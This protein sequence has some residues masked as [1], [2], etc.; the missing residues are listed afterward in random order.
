MLNELRLRYERLTPTISRLLSWFN[1]DRVALLVAALVLSMGV[2]LPWYKI[3]PENLK[4]FNIGLSVTNIGRVVAALFACLCFA[5][6]IWHQPSRLPRLPIWSGLIGTLLFPYMLTTWSPAVDFIATSLYFQGQSVTMHVKMNSNKVQSQWKKNVQLTQSSP[7]SSIFDLSIRTSRFF[8]FSLWDRILLAGLGYSRPF[9]A[10]VGRG[11]VMTSA[12]LAIAV[13]AIYLGLQSE[14]YR[15]FLHDMGRILPWSVLLLGVLTF[16]MILPSMINYQLDAMFARG[17]YHQVIST[18][19]A[20]ISF[21]PPVKGDEPFLKRMA[22]AGYYGKEPDPSLINFAQGLE[23]Y[24]LKDFQAAEAYFQKSLD[25]QPERFLVRGYLASAILSQ[26]VNFYNTSYSS[27]SPNDRKPSAAIDRLEQ[28]LQIFP[29][30]IEAL[31]DLMLARTG[32]DEFDKSALVAQEIIK[33]ERNAQIPN[34]SLLG[35]AYLHSTWATYQDG[36][37]EKAWK[38]FRQSTDTSTWGDTTTWG[39]TE[40]VEK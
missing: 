15:Y 26:A 6:A 25:I 22:E 5:F 33:A 10:F 16:S 34:L 7:I 18:S 32:N 13:I 12:G 40:G 2:L 28:I 11:W 23:S 39:E 31:Y 3:S 37:T 20:L 19:K 4:A 38:K 9:F 30:H 27:D 17:E 24:R 1:R 36:D 29:G 21:Y 14:A 35:Q 8:Q